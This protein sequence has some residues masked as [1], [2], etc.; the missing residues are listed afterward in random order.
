[1]RVQKVAM[2]RSRQDRSIDGT[3]DQCDAECGERI[4]QA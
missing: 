1:M 4:A 2:S 3:V